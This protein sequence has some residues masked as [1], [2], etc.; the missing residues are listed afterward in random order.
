MKLCTS[1]LSI[2]EIEIGIIAAFAA[3]SRNCDVGEK[4]GFL[5]GETR[6]VDDSFSETEKRSWNAKQEWTETKQLAKKCQ[7]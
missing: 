7:S 6:N 5:C 1:H 4:K 3:N 2:S